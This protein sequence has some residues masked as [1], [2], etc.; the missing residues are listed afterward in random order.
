[1]YDVTVGA[2]LKSREGLLVQFAAE[3]RLGIQATRDLLQTVAP[4]TLLR[5]AVKSDPLSLGEVSIS[6]Y[7]E[8]ERWLDVLTRRFGFDGRSLASH[9]TDRRGT[10]RRTAA[11]S[12]PALRFRHRPPRLA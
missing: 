8:Y 6:A 7:H 11:K 5:N 3:K 1:M 4:Q 10:G 2:V 9:A 12:P